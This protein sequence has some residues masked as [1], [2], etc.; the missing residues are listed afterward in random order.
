LGPCSWHEE[1]ALSDGMKFH[2]LNEIEVEENFA[3][4]EFV[5]FVAVENRQEIDGDDEGCVEAGGIHKRNLE[6]FAQVLRE[7][8]E[9][10]DSVV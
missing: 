4:Q 3:L 10:L 9:N 8:D 1:E 7:D 5:L 2:L 6:S